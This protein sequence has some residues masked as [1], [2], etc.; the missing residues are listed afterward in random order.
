MTKVRWTS[1]GWH[2]GSPALQAE[3][4][5]PPPPPWVGSVPG[6]ALALRNTKG[7]GGTSAG[8]TKT[9]ITA[10]TARVGQEAGAGWRG[11][12]S[13]W[14]VEA[15]ENALGTE[16]LSRHLPTQGQ[17]PAP[18]QRPPR[19]THTQ[20][21]QPESHVTKAARPAKGVETAGQREE[22]GSRCGACRKQRQPGNWIR[23][24][25][26]KVSQEARGTK[27]Q[28]QQSMKPSGVGRPQ[29]RWLDSAATDGEAASSPSGV[30]TAPLAFTAL[31]W[32]PSPKPSPG[33][34]QDLY[35]MS[36]AQCRPQNTR[37]R[38]ATPAPAAM[39]PPK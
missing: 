31:A 39:A 19:R 23:R 13:A 1:Q 21:P 29:S 24:R 28:G 14:Q 36:S 32:R 22:G 33:Q 11:P 38:V 15:P 2:R 26:E 6:S 18:T 10:G 9:L 8:V 12:R 35:V 7:L 27:V 16:E 25:T 34:A 5:Y 20:T 30:F 37:I 3:R 17:H 4:P